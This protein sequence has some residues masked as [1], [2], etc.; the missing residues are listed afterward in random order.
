MTFS[1]SNK[2]NII[3]FELPNA[4]TAQIFNLLSSCCRIPCTS[5]SNIQWY[6]WLPIL[7]KW[8]FHVTTVS[9]QWLNNYIVNFCRGKKKGGGRQ[10]QRQLKRPFI[11]SSITFKYQIGKKST[12]QNWFKV[13]LPENSIVM[14]LLSFY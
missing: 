7:G 9:W 8:R 5:M 3:K 13:K 6:S 14:S 4:N 11:I 1:R 2:F 12:S 10:K